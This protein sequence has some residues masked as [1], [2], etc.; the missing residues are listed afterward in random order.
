MKTVTKSKTPFFLGIMA[1]A[2]KMCTINTHTHVVYWDIQN[3]RVSFKKELKASGGL[4]MWI[5]TG[6][7]T[8]GG[9]RKRSC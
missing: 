4:P 8:L 7:S 9:E 6:K 3:I 1:G 5:T 2:Q